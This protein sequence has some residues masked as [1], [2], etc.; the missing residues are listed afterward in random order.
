M[1]GRVDAFS[2]AVC[3]PIYF[4]SPSPLSP[5]RD[6]LRLLRGILHFLQVIA[7]NWSH[8]AINFGHTR[9][10]SEGKKMLLLMM[11]VNMY[12]VSFLGLLWSVSRLC[13][14]Y[15]YFDCFEARCVMFEIDES[16]FVKKRWRDESR[17]ESIPKK[18]KSFMMQSR[19]EREGIWEQQWQ[20]WAIYLAKY[21][22]VRWCYSAGSQLEHLLVSQPASL[23]H[24]EGE[25]VLG[26]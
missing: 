14:A 8:L 18:W 23:G 25:K 26:V 17:D 1:D 16:N 22:L 12:F 10:A 24:R 20:E 9:H 3:R 7:R 2:S 13:C 11:T 15:A 4:I 5:P 6:G 21:C 19:Q